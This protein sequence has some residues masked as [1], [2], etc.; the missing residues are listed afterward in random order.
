[1]SSLSSAPRHVELKTT[2]I[3]DAIL[4]SGVKHETGHNVKPY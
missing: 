4:V 2:T 3:G 1:M